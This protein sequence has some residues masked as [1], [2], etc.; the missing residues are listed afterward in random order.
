MKNQKHRTG[1]PSIWQIIN[2]PKNPLQRYTLSFQ[3]TKK[4]GKHDVQ[5]L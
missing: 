4:S 2:L 1:L 3:D 5:Y